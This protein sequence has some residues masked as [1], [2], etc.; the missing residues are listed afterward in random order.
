MTTFR[1]PCTQL[2]PEC[3]DAPS[4]H[5]AD[6]RT[7]HRAAGLVHHL[8]HRGIRNRN[9][10]GQHRNGISQ[11]RNP[12][13]VRK[14]TTLYSPGIH[15]VRITD[16]HKLCKALQPKVVS[17]LRQNPA[18]SRLGGST[19]AHPACKESPTPPK[20]YSAPRH[21]RAAVCLF[22]SA[23]ATLCGGVFERVFPCQIVILMSL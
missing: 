21:L 19:G 1:R 11:V 16:F 6:D 5:H 13:R 8:A 4:Q 23:F 9:R 3:K 7:D 22:A 20:L 15:A 17:Q 12:L 10:N 14:P 2:Y 18:C